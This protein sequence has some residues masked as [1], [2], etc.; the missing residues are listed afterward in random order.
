MNTTEN[1][2]QEKSNK[3]GIPRW[4]ALLVALAFWVIGIPLFYGV[5]PWGI[6]LLTPR[7]G[8]AADRPGLWNLLGLIPVLVGS[9]CLIWIMLLHF[10]Q[11][12]ERVELERTPSYLLRQGP[13]AFSR[14]PLYLSELALLFG[15]SIFYGSVAVL[16]AFVVA[17]VLLNFVKIPHEEHT[18]DARFGEAYREYKSR[19]PRWFYKTRR[20]HFNTNDA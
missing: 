1:S 8:W 14:H 16:I 15:W 5:G 20:D 17:C 10:A 11:A 9:M 12:P 7:H 13:Y 4:T 18:L 3:A 19:V 6:S 2:N